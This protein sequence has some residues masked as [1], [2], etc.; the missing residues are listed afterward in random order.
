MTCSRCKANNKFNAEFCCDCGMSFSNIEMHA[1]KLEEVIRL[2][3][4]IY[5]NNF[6]LFFMLSFVVS[7]LFVISSVIPQPFNIVFVAIGC[8]AFVFLKSLGAL[9]YCHDLLK[10]SLNAELCINW[11][12]ARWR[13]LLIG[14]LLFISVLI[15]GIV[16]SLFIIGLPLLLYCL[17]A[18][19]FYIYAILFQ[20]SQGAHSLL[21]SREL[22]LNNWW[23]VFGIIMAWTLL[24]SVIQVL[25]DITIQ[26][27]NQSTS[28]VMLA[29]YGILKTAF[30]ALI[31]PIEIL[32]TAILYFDL[33]VR[34]QEYSLE[35]LKHEC[36]RM[37]D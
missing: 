4:F 1:M 3:F 14:T 37:I 15:L 25:F 10:I 21:L 7:A 30:F 24:Q 12:I 34:N 31:L 27:L 36:K 9:V 13:S 26:E 28:Q 5:K 20:N 6:Y 35:D 32:L 17:I 22:I 11:I 2:T 29:F 23:R 16:L 18:F 33:R 8:V 19:Q